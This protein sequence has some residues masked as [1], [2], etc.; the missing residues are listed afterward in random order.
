MA[1][2]AKR[3][4][5]SKIKKP[6]NDLIRTTLGTYLKGRNYTVSNAINS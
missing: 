4:Q 6:R 1:E 2:S 3:Q 5:N